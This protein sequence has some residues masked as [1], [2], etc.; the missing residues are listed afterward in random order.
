MIRRNAASVLLALAGLS[1]LVG[2]GARATAAGT[3]TPDYQ[4]AIRCTSGT[5]SVIN[6][7]AHEPT[8]ITSVVPNETGKYLTVNHVAV[9]EVGSVQV[10]GDS[11]YAKVGITT[12]GPSAGLTYDRIEL[13]DNGVL[14]APAAACGY[15]YTN[16]WITGWAG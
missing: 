12:Y 14:I 9:T 1:M 13:F 2:A 11:D 16:I 6:D 4:G 7:S 3:N 10:T 15:A 5:W 8:G